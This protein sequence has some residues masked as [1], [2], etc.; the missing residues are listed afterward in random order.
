MMTIDAV[1]VRDDRWKLTNHVHPVCWMMY[2]D[3]SHLKM[4]AMTL[5]TKSL[6]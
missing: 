2:H 6:P 5:R 3:L 4:M 1:E